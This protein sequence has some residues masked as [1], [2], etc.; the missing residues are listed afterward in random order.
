MCEAV[1]TKECPTCKGFGLLRLPDAGPYRALVCPRCDGQGW[2]PIRYKPFAG[3]HVFATVTE[4][5][6]TSGV[7][8]TRGTVRLPDRITPEQFELEYPVTAPRG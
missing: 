4:I 1:V 6:T 3:R 2:A 5:Q 7:S 8:R